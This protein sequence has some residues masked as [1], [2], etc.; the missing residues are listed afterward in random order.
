M[1]CLTPQATTVLGFPVRT[2]PGGAYVPKT[3]QAVSSLIAWRNAGQGTPDYWLR[4]IIAVAF[5]RMVTRRMQ[6]APAADLITVA[7][8]DWLDIVGEKMEQDI[9]QERIVVAFRRI[10]RECSRWPQPAD[11]IKRLPARIMPRQKHTMEAPISDEDHA[12]AAA[13]FAEILASLK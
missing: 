6:D 3:V 13:K 9:D 5:E 7:A 2:G 1:K 4:C 8:E 12:K 10:F 11:L